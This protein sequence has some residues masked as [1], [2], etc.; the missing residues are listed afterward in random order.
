[1][2][3]QIIIARTKPMRKRQSSG[4]CR[5]RKKR[6]SILTAPLPFIQI[7]VLGKAVEKLVVS[8]FKIFYLVFENSPHETY[9]D[10]QE[11]NCRSIVAATAQEP[12]EK[13]KQSTKYDWL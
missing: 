2:S 13:A 10:S 8:A 1:L 4:G 9:R 6:G 11:K 3:W 5:R 12:K 7:S